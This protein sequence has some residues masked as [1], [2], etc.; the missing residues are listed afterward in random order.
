[1]DL[2]GGSLE[3]RAEKTKKYIREQAKI[4]YQAVF[5]GV[6]EINKIPVSVVSIPDF[7]IFESSGWII[8]DA[9]LARHVD[10]GEHPEIE[11]QLQLYGLLLEKTTG[12]KPS[13]LE[14]LQGDNQIIT[15]EYS[16][17]RA[18][19]FL[20]ELLEVVSKPE[21]PYSPVGWTRCQSCGYVELCWEKSVK[22][23]DVAILPGV[24]KGLA[25]FLKKEGI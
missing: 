2:S 25:I 23:R 9:K 19:E 21:E 11:G 3:T 13:H 20:A 14:V 15:L 4:I 10:E 12:E 6:T 22:N 24:D 16:G 7:L 18:K 1:M 8:R 5:T 17:A